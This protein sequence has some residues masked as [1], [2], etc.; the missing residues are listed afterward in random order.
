MAK[1]HKGNAKFTVAEKGAMAGEKMCH[2]NKAADGVKDLTRALN[3]LGVKPT[4]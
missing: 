3:L 1:T 2:A 4:A